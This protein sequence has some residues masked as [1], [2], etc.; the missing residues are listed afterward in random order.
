MASVYDKDG[1]LYVSW[2]DWNENKT[3]NRS[4]RMSATV[5]NRRTANAFAKKLQ[6]ELDKQKEVN[7]TSALTRG[8]TIREAFDHFKRN[9]ASK[10]HKTIKDYDRFF[11]K[12]T[13]TFAETSSCSVINKISAEEWINSLKLL[14]H[15][16]N[17]IH[18]YFKQFNHFLNFLFEYGYVPMFKINRDVKTKPE[19]K[20]KIVFRDEDIQTIFGDLSTKN[21]N[22]KL[23]VSMLFYTG[24]R[25][26]DI[27]N[28][29]REQID[30]KNQSFSYYSPKRKKFRE[31][32]FHADLLP[33]LT[34]TLKTKATGKLIDYKC[35]EYVNRAFTR[36]LDDIKLA[37]RDYTAR[38][39]RKTFIT[40]CRSRYNMDATVVRELV[41][42]EHNNTTDRYYNHVSLERMKTELT[43][44]IRPTVEL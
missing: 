36:Y 1:T 6:K 31:V 27:L 4:L 17:T 41:G 22:F 2:W 7:D 33:I 40:L 26:S 8:S 21:D 29:N 37:G 11:N 30:L 35:V 16:I 12:F 23:T 10:H 42:H 32:A 13:E 5:T 38:T 43:K 39:F 20:E 34:E 19:V 15:S 9:N 24:L 28:I 18:G 44:F 3:K 14:P 25:S